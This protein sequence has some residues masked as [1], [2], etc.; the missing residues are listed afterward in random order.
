MTDP[1]RPAD[2]WSRRLEAD[3]TL[4]GTGHQ[5]YSEGYNAW[6]YR[7]KGRALDRAL[8]GVQAP[9]AA[10]D[11]GSG[12]GWVVERLRERGYAVEGCD[13]ADVA[14]ERLR[15]RFPTVP[16]FLADVGSE[17]LPRP[18]ASYDVITMLDVA[19]H[20]VDEDRFDR[21]VA[22]LARVLRPGGRVVVTDGL[23]GTTVAPAPHV[24]FRSRSRWEH[25]AEVNGLAVTDVFACFRWIS[26]DPDVPLL[27]RLPGR[28]RGALEYALDRTVPRSPFLRCAV[29]ERPAG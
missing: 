16:F 20:V 10:L 27:E 5:C 28:V 6:L 29:L 26:R 18:D 15:A 1:Y 13:I 7:A 24:R 21:A 25:A 22:D 17:P 23:A 12:V 9:A 8:R 19:Y 11:V 14:V 2:Y 4:R 3:F